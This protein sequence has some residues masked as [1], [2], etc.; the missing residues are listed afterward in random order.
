[1]FWHRNDFPITILCLIWP[2]ECSIILTVTVK[3][4]LENL[5]RDTALYLLSIL[6]KIS[7]YAAKLILKVK[8]KPFLYHWTHGAVFECLVEIPA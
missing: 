8:I 7:L 4:Y 6:K 2:F 1:M 3:N 5:L